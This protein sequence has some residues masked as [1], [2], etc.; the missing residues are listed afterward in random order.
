[1]KPFTPKT[2][3]FDLDGTLVDTAPDLAFA[4]NNV[5]K[6]NHH[7]PLPFEQIRPLVGQGGKSLIKLGFKISEA[8][9]EF[10]GLWQELLDIYELHIYEKSV[11]FP[12]MEQVLTYL[13]KNNT[14]W[15]VVT[16]KPYRLSEILLKKMALWSQVSCLVGGDTLPQRKPDPEPLWHACELLN[17]AAQESIYIGDSETDI[18]T[19]KRAGMPVIA[20]AYGY[21]TANEQPQSWGADYVISKPEELLPI[22]RFK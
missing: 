12:G 11:L 21:L 7:P 16:N 1:M 4:L 14:R 8:H 9:P 5:L 19:A 18:V 3:L 6:K 15:G 22:L 17:C 2:V 20:A 10:F 13:T